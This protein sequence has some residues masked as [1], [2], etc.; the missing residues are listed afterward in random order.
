MR[1]ALTAAAIALSAMVWTGEA[2]WATPVAASS[3]YGFSADLTFRGITTILHPVGR[4]AGQAPPAYN[5]SRKIK[6]RDETIRLNPVTIVAPML[7]F[8]AQ[9]IRTDAASAGIASASG[10]AKIGSIGVS[11]ASYLFPPIPVAALPNQPLPGF[12]GLSLTAKDIQSSS[13]YSG[14]SDLA[15]GFL[16]GDASFGSLTLSGALIGGTLTFSGNAAPNTVVFSTPTVTVTL[17]RQIVSN[18]ISCSLVCTPT[19]TSIMTDAIDISLHDAMVFGRMM[20]GN[21]VIGQSFADPVPVP[22]AEPGALSLLMIG[23]AGAVGL[24]LRAVRAAG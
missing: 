12:V 4:V 7:Q 6:N 10:S 5:D 11:L 8:D 16:S 13:S 22:A 19:P 2:A 23:I 14:L 15:H 24:R 21:I 17:D 18:L 3:A 1:I 20:S 9:N